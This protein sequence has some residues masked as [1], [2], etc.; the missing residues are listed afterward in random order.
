M[1]CQVLMPLKAKTRDGITE[2]SPGQIIS[3]D[4]EKALRLLEAGKVRSL[5]P[6]PAKLPCER[7]P[8][9]A[10]WE[11]PHGKGWH[12]FSYAYFYPVRGGKPRLCEEA[13]KDCG[14]KDN[15]ETLRGRY[16]H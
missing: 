8:A 6:E 11:S 2:L 5:E 3:I 12:C 4:Y 15:I 1:K 10:W 9:G 14:H 13:I 16:R 7:C